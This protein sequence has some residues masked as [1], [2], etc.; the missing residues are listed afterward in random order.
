MEKIDALVGGPLVGESHSTDA[1]HLPLAFALVHP[2]KGVALK[3]KMSA[4]C[5]SSSHHSCV[6]GGQLS[7]F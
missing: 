5:I 4:A 3:I 7:G 6:F 1:T 2:G